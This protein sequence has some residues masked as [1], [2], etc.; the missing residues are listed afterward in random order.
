MKEININNKNLLNKIIDNVKTNL[1]KI[2]S[3]IFG[4]FLIFVFIQLYS[5]YKKNKILKDSI[6][7]FNLQDLN[8]D[9]NLDDQFLKLSKENNFY[10]FLSTLELIESNLQNNKIEETKN[11]YFQLLENKSI[12]KIY[13]SALASKASYEF[14]DFNL[15]NPAENYIDTINIFISYID[16]DVTTYIG[17][18]L[19]LRYLVSILEIEKNKLKYSDFKKALDLFDNIMNSEIVSS[20]TKERINK[21]H[22]YFSIN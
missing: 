11:L 4:I 9:I 14:I 10:S 12:D 2:I 21:I 3:L 7:F 17:I 13:K 22:E 8:E 15:N 5:F 1:K 16:D 6:S 19:E 20:V 18:K